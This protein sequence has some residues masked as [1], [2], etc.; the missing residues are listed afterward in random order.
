MLGRGLYKPDPP[1][2]KEYRE[3]M[4]L[5]SAFVHMSICAHI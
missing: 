1:K 3:G 4:M 2:S 5:A